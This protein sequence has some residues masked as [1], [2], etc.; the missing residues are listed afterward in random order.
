MK[1][2]RIEKVTE[3]ADV[4]TSRQRGR[5]T[6]IVWRKRRV[7]VRDMLLVYVHSTTAPLWPPF[8]GIYLGHP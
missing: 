3:I 5:R 8:P 2:K 4:K 6:E 7:H 1:E